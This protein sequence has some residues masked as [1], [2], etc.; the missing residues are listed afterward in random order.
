M[1]SNATFSKKNL[2]TLIVKSQ[3]RK[4][5]L[6]TRPA[7][8]R[9]V[10]GAFSAVC[11]PVV[12]AVVVDSAHCR[13]AN[14]KQESVRAFL[15]NAQSSKYS[16]TLESQIRVTKKNLTNNPHYMFWVRIMK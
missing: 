13:L 15:T 5:E 10:K 8:G 6:V 12:G 3:R 1:R 14:V 7:T 16:S 9:V 4:I 2:F 11:L